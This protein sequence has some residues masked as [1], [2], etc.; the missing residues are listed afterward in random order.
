MRFLVIASGSA[1]ELFAGLPFLAAFLF[2]LIQSETSEKYQSFWAAL[3]GAF[4][5]I[6]MFE[7]TSYRMTVGLGGAWLLWKCFFNGKAA[8]KTAGS[9][10][11]FN[12]ISFVISLILV[13]LPTIVQTIREP[14]SSI[15]F[16]ALFVMRVNVHHYFPKDIY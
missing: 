4:A 1:D 2:G 7:Y 15:F 8:K 11:W 10:S 5:G 13:A 6:L 3:A 9:A 16:E 14:N 12:L